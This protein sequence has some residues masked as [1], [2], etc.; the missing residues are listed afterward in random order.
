[1]SFEQGIALVLSGGGVR[2]AAHIGVLEVF[3]EL[4]IEIRSIAGSSMGA[5]VAA[6]YATGTLPDLKNWLLSLEQQSFLSLVDFQISW[7]GFIRG[8]RLMDTIRDIIPDMPIE[9]LRIPFACVAVD[10]IEGEECVFRSGRL[11]QA[12]RASIA[13]PTIIRPQVTE[14]EFLVDGGVLN[15]LPLDIVERGKELPLVAVD[16]CAPDDADREIQ[17]LAKRKGPLRE[18][19]WFD[20]IWKS[21]G[22]ATMSKPSDDM[23]YFQI[24]NRSIDVMMRHMTRLKIAQ[25]QPEMLLQIPANLCSMFAVEECQFL[26]EYGRAQA[27]HALDSMR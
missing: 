21:F 23:G 9:A 7:Q 20:S 4:N 25:H 8:T 17:W 2:G 3:D 22:Q 1:M 27:I 11:L 12:L 19:G 24:M 10:L 16:V 6:A 18:P 14:K 5:L 26:Y 13:V 15:N